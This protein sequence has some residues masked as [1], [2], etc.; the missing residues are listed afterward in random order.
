MWAASVGPSID[1]YREELLKAGFEI[2]ESGSDLNA[3]AKIEN[4]S[5][6]CSP[7]MSMHWKLCPFDHG[8][9]FHEFVRCNQRPRPVEESTICHNRGLRADII[10]CQPVSLLPGDSR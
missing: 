6:C 4:Q 5:A 8:R 2:V 3:Y 1:P 9:Q 7:A 10:T